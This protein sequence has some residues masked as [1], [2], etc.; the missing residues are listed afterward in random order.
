MHL[1]RTLGE[2]FT[3]SGA[4]TGN[5][6][7]DS[8]DFDGEYAFTARGTWSPVHTADRA[9][10]LGLAAGWRRLDE[11]LQVRARPEVHLAGRPVVDN[12][13]VPADDVQV[14]GLDG[15]WVA[16]PAVAPG[17]VRALR[18]GRD[19]AGVRGRR[20]L[21]PGRQ[22]VPHRRI[23]ALRLRLRGL[24]LDEGESPGRRGRAR[25][26]GTGSALRHPGPGRLG[27]PRPR[28]RRRR[29]WRDRQPDPGAELVPEQQHDVPAQLCPHRWTAPEPAR[30]AWAT[31]PAPS[32]RP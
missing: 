20:G 28:P 13:F 17:R 2:R 5:R 10:H 23:A 22:L 9:I 6:V 18:P 29:R 14:I 15:A 16:G 32:P 8:N 1:T 21:V 27:V 24:R 4:F 7:S 25:C 19:R 11:R 3:L 30:R 26:L 31:P 12:D